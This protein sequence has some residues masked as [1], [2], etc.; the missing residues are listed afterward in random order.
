MDSKNY[1]EPEDGGR[2]G[3]RPVKSNDQKVGIDEDDD[4]SFDILRVNASDDD[5]EEEDDNDATGVTGDEEKGD[6]K[7]AEAADEV[8]GVGQPDVMSATVPAGTREGETFHINV[9]GRG[10]M[11]LVVPMGSGP[12]QVIRFK[13]H[14]LQGG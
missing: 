4:I 6:E 12:G 9:P 2:Y 3:A 14:P 5:E 10:M 1:T 7:A 11:A 13:L 8:R